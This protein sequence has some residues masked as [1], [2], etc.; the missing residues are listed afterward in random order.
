MATILLA[1]LAYDLEASIR[2]A[3]VRQ[4]H[5]VL[6]A[7]DTPQLF[8]VVEQAQPALAILDPTLLVGGHGVQVCCDLRARPAGQNLFMIV[9][10]N[11]DA[12]GDKLDAFAAGADDYLA[13]PFHIPELLLRVEALLRRQARLTRKQAPT[14]PLRRHGDI[15]L[16][17]HTGDVWRGERRIVVTPVEARLLNYL[18]TCAGRAV[19]AEELLQQVWTQAPGCGDPALVRVHIRHLRDKLAGIFD[20]TAEVLK[21]IPRFGYCMAPA[22]AT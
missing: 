1:G 5:T 19:S 12:V 15:A 20:N 11:R 4:G 2:R 8:Q 3:L 22:G 21:T 13:L 16:D 9:I 6:V 17:I 18:M 7:F 14:H 10:S